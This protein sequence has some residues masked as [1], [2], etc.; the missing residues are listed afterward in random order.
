MTSFSNPVLVRAA[1]LLIAASLVAL[2]A[3]PLLAVTAGIL[4]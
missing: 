4:S 1:A 2:G 3:Q